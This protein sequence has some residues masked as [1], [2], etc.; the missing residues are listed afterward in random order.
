VNIEIWAD[1]ICPW[2]G[3]GAHRLDRAVAEARERGQ[4]VTL[5][6]HAFQLEPDA[7]AGTRAVR[8]MLAS[9][10]YGKGQMIASWERIESMAAREGLA[11]Y[12]LDNITGNTRLAHELLAFASTRG[13][14]EAA[15]QTM[16]RAYFG[17]KRP[18]FTVDDLVPIG[19]EMGLARDEVRAV[20][21]DGTF[22]AR[23]DAD[24]R[25]AA[26]LGISGV[27]FVLLD[28]ERVLHGAQPLEVFRQALSAHPA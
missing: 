1:I 6:H 25:E 12:Q 22:A 15:W 18:I 26:S 11:P 27:P 17:Q 23:V 8:D 2:C 19:E 4:D 14:E 28:R 9:R 7:P 5:V 16:Y 3:L 10:G 21:D 20:L 13:H 24:L